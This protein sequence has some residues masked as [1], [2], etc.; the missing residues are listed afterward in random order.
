MRLNPK[1]KPLRVNSRIYPKGFVPHP[2]DHA[3]V[4]TDPRSGEL[5]TASFPSTKVL[6]KTCELTRGAF[7]WGAG[8]PQVPRLRSG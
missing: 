3:S 7:A 1:Q 8:A 6:G 2:P 5:R 4:G